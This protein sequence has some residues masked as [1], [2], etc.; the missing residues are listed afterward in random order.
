M[1]ARLRK[2]LGRV[3]WP[4]RWILTRVVIKIVG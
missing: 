1:P 3:I 4:L 2:R